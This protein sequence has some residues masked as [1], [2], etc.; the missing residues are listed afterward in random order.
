MVLYMVFLKV[1]AQS[2]N[3]KMEKCDKLSL[4]YCEPFKIYMKIGD[5]AYRLELPEGI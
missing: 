2:K 4:K 3:L 5:V 1:L